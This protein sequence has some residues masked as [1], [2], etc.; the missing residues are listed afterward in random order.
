MAKIKT[1]LFDLGG[2]L[3]ELSGVANMMSWSDLT[4]DEI[5]HRWTRSASVRKFE[6]GECSADYFS[7]QIVL[8]FALTVS[9][10]SFLDAFAA[11]PV[12][13]PGACDLLEHLSSRFTLACLSNTNHL[14]WQRF[15][16][17]TELLSHFHITLP[18]H[19][20]GKVKPDAEVYYHALDVL[21]QK[22]ESI[23]F[24]DDNQP[25]IESARQAG[26]QAELTR[27]LTGVVENLEARGLLSGY[28]IPVAL[29]LQ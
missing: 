26:I 13:Y 2:V 28:T 19:I 23:F 22:P 3:V 16:N 29:G 6:S 8:E 15:E 10:E 27:S 25:N 14:H 11:W 24:M 7:R 18:S 1:L 9:P 4:E 20:T 17:E 12:P 5:W 21:D